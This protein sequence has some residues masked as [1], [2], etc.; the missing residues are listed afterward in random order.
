MLVS[1]Y[2]NTHLDITHDQLTRQGTQEECH[3]HSIAEEFICR[4]VYLYPVDGGKGEHYAQFFLY[5]IL[6][7]NELIML[8]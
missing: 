4:H 7:F 8:W 5:F 2:K 3:G 6:F 1:S